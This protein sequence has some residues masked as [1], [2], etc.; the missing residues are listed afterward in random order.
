MVLWSG[1]EE[2]GP[3]LMN[4]AAGPITAEPELEPEPIQ[5]SLP[6]KSSAAPSGNGGAVFNPHHAPGTGA[7]SPAA[8]GQ[9]G[10]RGQGSGCF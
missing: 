5:T 7:P 3:V 9:V 8:A 2:T 1:A 4:R 10:V 6:Q